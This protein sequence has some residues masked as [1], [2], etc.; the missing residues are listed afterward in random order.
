MP[1]KVREWTQR[2][3]TRPN[4]GLFRQ[5]GDF[6]TLTGWMP[7]HRRDRLIR[8]PDW[9]AHNEWQTGFDHIEGAFYDQ[10]NKY[11]VFLGRKSADDELAAVYYDQ[12]WD[13]SS[14]IDLNI[15][16][17]VYGPLAGYH[18]RNL[19]YWDGVLYCICDNWDVYR[20]DWTSSLT[21]LWDAPAGESA[22]LLC[23]YGDRIYMANNAG[24]IYKLNATDDGMDAFYTPRASLDIRYMTPFHQYLAL[25]TRDDDGWIH[26]LRLP[27]VNPY[28]IHDVAHIQS[29][30][31]AYLYNTPFTDGSLFATIR[32]EIYFTSGWYVPDTDTVLDVYAFDGTQIRR[33]TQI[34]DLPTVDNIRSAGLL[35]WRNELLFWYVRTD[36]TAQMLR[37]LYG[38]GHVDMLPA[39]MPHS[40]YSAAY[41]LGGELVIVAKDSG[42]TDEGFYH[43]SST[44]LYDATYQSSRF[45]A[46]HP[47]RQKRLEQITVLMDQE[48][49][50]TN[51]TIKYRID[52]ATA[53]TT[54]LADSSGTRLHHAKAIAIDFYTIQIQVLI[55]DEAGAFRNY[56]IEAISVIYSVDEGALQMS[57]IR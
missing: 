54:A 26:V 2:E 11:Y 48:E 16:A 37:L 13:K 18:Q 34:R 53:W 8:A 22:R 49:S 41:S 43:T 55:A 20:G 47:G 5:K 29:A 52:D 12:N 10:A 35:P 31:G 39:T 44:H 56:A 45:D 46:G 23:V 50:D 33:V 9:S 51:I 7:N 6:D 25:I 3:W 15:D 19:R 17:S 32:D 1:I 27:D 21:K 24:K 14:I 57:T 28:V 38:G 30:S 4:I 40:N 36:S 42:N